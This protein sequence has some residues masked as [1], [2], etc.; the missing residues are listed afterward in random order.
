MFSNS[1]PFQI[2]LP[3]HCNLMRPDREQY[4]CKKVEILFVLNYYDRIRS[5][6]QTFGGTGPY[7]ESVLEN[8]IF[9]ILD[10]L[11]LREIV[12]INIREEKISRLDRTA[13]LDT[14]Q[15]K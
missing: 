1:I 13:R 2:D 4:F 6:F 3:S 7:E 5:I 9:R 11:D 15:C 8:H 12:L 14:F 10:L